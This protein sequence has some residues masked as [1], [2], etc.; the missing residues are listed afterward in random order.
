MTLCGDVF[1]GEVSEAEIRSILCQLNGKID[2]VEGNHDTRVKKKIY[3]EYFKNISAYKYLRMH[4]GDIVISHIP[5]SEQQFIKR[6]KANIHGHLHSDRVMKKIYRGNT[7]DSTNC[8]H[9]PFYDEVID[10]RYINVCAEHH[11]LTP[12]HKDVLLK[13]LKGRT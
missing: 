8:V 11:N 4:D 2:C 12:V 13:G 1:V 10:E 3:A 6:Y 7:F 5:V 9:I